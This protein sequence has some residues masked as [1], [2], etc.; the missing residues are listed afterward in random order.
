MWKP[1]DSH[2]PAAL[3]SAR[4]ALHW[5]AQLV[6]APG[7]TLLEP[8]ADFSH[9]N[10]GW[11]ESTGRIVGRDLD[12][13]R[14]RAALRISE[15]ELAV[16]RGEDEVVGNLS[17]DGSSYD[18]AMSWLAQTL[19][20][21]TPLARSEHEMP[22]HPVNGGANFD[23]A[24]LE[25]GLTELEAWLSNAH[26][27]IARAIAPKGGASEVR[28]WPHHLDI[29]C[30]VT[31]EGSGEEA[32]SINVGLSLGD[33]S[34]GE[35]YWYI[36]PWPYPEARRDDIEL[37]HGHWHTD[38]FYAAI[39]SAE[40]LRASGEDQAKHAEAFVDQGYVACSRMLAD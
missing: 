4:L 25:S 34:Y 38:G 32:K 24:G 39:L 27:L 18:A 10:L 40:E 22:E 7:T 36:S 19:G 15:L 11:E 35:P 20:R 37:P 14:T 1:L 17:L 2:A 26:H 29:A 9:T 16:L 33:G 3:T 12:E 13:R 5:A 6:S 8:Q 31:L 30:L 23:S 28:L 21:D